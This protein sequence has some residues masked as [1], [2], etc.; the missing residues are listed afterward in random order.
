MLSMVVL[1]TLSAVVLDGYFT[2]GPRIENGGIGGWFARK[3]LITVTRISALS[4]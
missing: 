1:G 2:A 4:S 3:L